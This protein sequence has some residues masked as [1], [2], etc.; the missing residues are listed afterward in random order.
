MKERKQTLGFL[1]G[2]A[3]YAMAANLNSM[4][5]HEGIDLPHSQY[6]VLKV[7]YE[8]DG[9]SQQE[10]AERVYKNVAAVKRTLDILESK[11]LVKRVPVTMRKNSI[12]ITEEG[13]KLLPQVLD[14][15]KNWEESILAGIGSR[16]YDTFENV[17]NTIYKNIK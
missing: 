8:K 16:E 7:L 11:G 12:L 10:L 14:C 2:R 5:K 9:I 15:I 3:S 13:K 17:L 1:L 6:V 4:L